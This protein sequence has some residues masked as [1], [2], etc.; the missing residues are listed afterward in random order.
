MNVAFLVSP[1]WGLGFLSLGFYPPL[2]LLSGCPNNSGQ[3]FGGPVYI[4]GWKEVQNQPR[5]QGPLLPVLRSELLG[6]GRRGP[7]ERGWC[8]TN[9]RISPQSYSPYAH[10]NSQGTLSCKKSFQR[11]RIRHVRYVNILTWPRGFWVEVVNLLSFFSSLNY[12]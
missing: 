4:P 1:R 10:Q 6:T 2:Q 11:Q 7:W 3:Q 8:R 9:F 5:S 12:Q